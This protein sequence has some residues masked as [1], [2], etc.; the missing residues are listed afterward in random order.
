MKPYLKPKAMRMKNIFKIIAFVV[1]LIPTV[2]LAE[3][4]EKNTLVLG[5]KYYNDN[6]AVQHLVISAKSKIDGKF[7][8]IANIA[9]KVFITS[10][11]DKNNLIGTGITSER[12]EFILLIPPAAKTEWAKSATQN[13]VAV[14]AATKLYEEARGEAETGSKVRLFVPIAALVSI[15]LSLIIMTATKKIYTYTDGGC[16]ICIKTRI[17]V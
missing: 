6:N 4:V 7:Q 11:A 3:T 15:L 14:S 8:K 12:G 13:F 2:L 5:V 17:F 9:V 16:I 1:Y 10:D